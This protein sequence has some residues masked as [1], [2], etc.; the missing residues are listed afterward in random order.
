MLNKLKSDLKNN[1]TIA[2]QTILLVISQVIIISS[3][4]VTKSIQTKNLIPSD[5]GVF[6]L[7]NTII[8]FTFTFFKFGFYVSTSNILANTKSERAEREI[9]G[10]ALLIGSLVSISYVIF[11]YAINPFIDSW[12]NADLSKYMFI[13]IPLCFIYS[14]APLIRLMGI[15][16]NKIKV[17]ASFDSLDKIFF[18]I[19]V[20][21]LALTSKITILNL[22]LAK[23]ICLIL[24]TA[25]AIYKLSPLFNNV[26]SHLDNIVEKTKEYG[27]KVYIGSS[28]GQVTFKID[29]LFISALIG[30]EDLGF[31]TL[32]TIICS[33]MTAISNSFTS[34]LIKKFANTNTINK[35]VIYYNTLWLVFCVISLLICADL[36]VTIILGDGY[37]K[38]GKLIRPL[39]FAAFFQGL[40]QPYGKFF[41][42]KGLGKE[43]RNVSIVEATFNVVGNSILIPIYGVY[44]AVGASIFARF[45]N[46]SLQFY[47]YTRYIRNS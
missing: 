3:G 12:F 25:I 44:G 21:S 16:S 33:P 43:S 39:A 41:L 28:L 5:Y 7:F 1:K 2:F 8:S 10:S 23:T 32:A 34:T 29:S 31:Y 38:V 9:Y 11:L 17:V 26:K 4:I 27:F 37:Q 36:I 20:I 24:S 13:V 46:F 22:M 45:L 35:K 47:Y 18:L 14:I 19:A 40:Y 15:G 42:A 6:A 30:V